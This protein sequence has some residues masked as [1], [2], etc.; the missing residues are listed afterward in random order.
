MLRHLRGLHVLQLS[1]IRPLKG[2]FPLS[3]TKS[4][5]AE[6][7]QLPVWAHKLPN[8]LVET[9]SFPSRNNV[10]PWRRDG[11]PGQKSC[12]GSSRDAQH[13]CRCQASLLQS[14][15]PRGVRTVLLCASSGRRAKD[16]L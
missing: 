7:S 5:Q 4:P 12:G 6:K 15:Q 2:A 13:F 1:I 10:L 14:P 16:H 3:Q 8:S 9:A 11:I